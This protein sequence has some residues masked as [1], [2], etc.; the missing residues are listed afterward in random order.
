ML[1]IVAQLQLQLLVR[2]TTILVREIVYS[3]IGGVLP[4]IQ[5]AVRVAVMSRMGFIMWLGLRTQLMI[6]GSPRRIVSS[7]VAQALVA[8]ARKITMLLEG[9]VLDALKAVLAG[10]A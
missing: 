4:V 6:A 5:A 8:L 10:I 9:I 1:L 7:V 3:A 2:V